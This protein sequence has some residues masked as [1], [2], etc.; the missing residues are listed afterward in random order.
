MITCPIL[1]IR[2]ANAFPATSN[3]PPIQSWLARAIK[4]SVPPNSELACHKILKLEWNPKKILLPDFEGML[5]TRIAL[6]L[7]VD[8]RKKAE[9]L[10]N[11]LDAEQRCRLAGEA[12][13][14]IYLAETDISMALVANNTPFCGVTLAV[15]IAGYFTLL[16]LAGGDGALSFS[17]DERNFE[18]H[19]PPDF[20]I[21][22]N[23]EGLEEE[24]SWTMHVIAKIEAFSKISATAT[25]QGAYHENVEP[26]DLFSGE[27]L[28]I[29]YMPVAYTISNLPQ[30]G[31]VHWSKSS[32]PEA[33]LHSMLRTAH[34]K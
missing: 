8:Q 3:A 16:A 12:S 7:A 19:L 9:D 30:K 15:M 22:P 5:V 14:M 34:T 26:D 13:L 32:R 24:I 28:A 11:G 10:V 33:L 4:S 27:A 17:L 6:L 31:K 18:G 29:P 20:E 2:L 21:P 23:P 25:L 1:A